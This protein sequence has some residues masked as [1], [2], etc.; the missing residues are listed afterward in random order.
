VSDGDALL[1]AIL[2][3]PAD[4]TPRLVYADWLEENGDAS[5]RLRAEFI[6][7][8]M[9]LAQIVPGPD[10]HAKAYRLLTRRRKGAPVRMRARTPATLLMRHALL[11]SPERFCE[12]FGLPGE[13]GTRGLSVSGSQVWVSYG[14]GRPPWTL[15]L[16]RGFLESVTL[17]AEAWLAHGPALCA[18][19]PVTEVRLAGKE[20]AR[21]GEVGV[22]YR[23]D[24]GERE[25]EADDLPPPPLGQA[26][27]AAGAAGHALPQSLL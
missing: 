13:P 7:L 8:Q 5:G 26:R 3:D 2:D 27:Q 6:R 11:L 16:R 22:W 20:P 21:V 18:L 14:K 24:G 9:E 23:F 19:H 12:W 25:E 15:T 10:D 1:H 17:P 4:D